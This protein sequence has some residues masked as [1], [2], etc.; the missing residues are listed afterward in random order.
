MK[1]ST[2]WGPCAPLFFAITMGASCASAPARVGTPA[3]KPNIV[4]IVA[5]D[6]GYADLGFQGGNKIPTPHIDSLATNGVRFTDAYVSAPLCSPSRA[7]LMTGRYP[8]R[9]GYDFNP[10]EDPTG[11]GGLPLDQTTLADRLKQAGYATGLVGKWHL[12]RE[13]D[14]HPPRRG[15]D[16]FFGFL[17]GVRSYFPITGDGYSRLMRGK[18]QV[19]EEPYLTRSFGREATAFIDRHRQ[20]P[21]FLYLA[22][23]AVHTPL[24]A[25]HD[26]L[27]RFPHIADERH[28]KYA[29]MLSA[30]DDAVGSVLAKL[31][32]AG[33]EDDTLIFFFSD[34]GGPIPPARSANT[35]SNRPL[36][37]SKRDTLEGGIR[38]P[39]VVQWKGRLP[40]NESYG[41]PII[42]FDVTATA[43]T[44]AGVHAEPL[45][46][47][48]VD[49]LPFVLG[50]RSGA[51]HQHLFWRF[52]RKM[53]VRQ[54]DWK[55]V[56]EDRPPARLY[57][58]R[59]DVAETTD[60]AAGHPAIVGRLQEAWD[61]WAATLA[62]PLW[63][64]P[65]ER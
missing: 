9:F 2:R 8:Q 15:F 21:F 63:P 24:E 56:I 12:G 1:S 60:L 33:V 39:F 46:L 4:I 51:P 30:M 23:N 6:L 28:R 58:L 45:N 54:G 14:F 50:S 11:K 57:N 18:E 5:D 47:D 27:R 43:L 42:Q 53:A 52:G 3:R 40:K 41:Q 17:T 32:D 38:V 62:P 34:N 37:G 36:R 49:L 61:G 20:R 13:P 35:S 44:A 31:R 7:G 10:D 19:A 48:G 26:D 59:R 64:D 65:L 16:E 29:A 55:L 22:F 25:T